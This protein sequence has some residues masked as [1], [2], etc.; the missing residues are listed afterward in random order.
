DESGAI[1]EGLLGPREGGTRPFRVTG[2]EEGLHED[3]LHER[4]AVLL[5]GGSAQHS[6]CAARMSEREL[7]TAESSL[8]SRQQRRGL[9]MHRRPVAR[10]VHR[11]LRRPS[12]IS[13]IAFAT[14]YVRRIELANA[15]NPRTNFVEPVERLVNCS[16]SFADAPLQA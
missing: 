12:G 15:S 3:E 16:A 14:G 10:G 7:G 1:P 13:E 9:R 2:S 6:V 5:H 4:L 8:T 11:R